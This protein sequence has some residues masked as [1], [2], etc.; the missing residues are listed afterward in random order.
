MAARSGSLR[1]YILT[2]LLLVI[3]NILV[4]LTM[5][6]LLMRVAPGD[7]VSAAL[8]G[9]LPPD[10]IA[11]RREAAGFDRPL[12]V[13]YW[14]YVSGV[15]RLDFG[16]TLTDNR[17][18]T[19]IFIVNGGATLTLTVAA[20]LVALVVGIPLGLYAGRRRDT[21][22]DVG[23][24]LFGILT[25]AAPV[26]FVGVLAQMLFT[27]KLGWLPSGKQAGAITQATTEEV[28]H[29][30]LLD[31]VLAGSSD[32]FIDGLKHLVMPAVVLGLLVTGVFIRLIRV[33]VAQ[34][35]RDDYV[36]AAQA[37]GVP[38]KKVVRHHAFR[39]ALVPFITVLGLQVALLF[40][41]AILTEQTFSWPGVGS[42]LIRYLTNRDYAAVQGIITVFALIVVLISL[43]I[44][45]VNALI[46]PRVR[47]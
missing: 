5:V 41:G 1:R 40:G 7:P 44:D 2:R 45:I 16:T 9:R 28:T 33:N 36:E 20:M 8:G 43:L 30:F 12:I 29:I 35:M 42:Q 18:V 3:P 10:E 46:D 34:T 4:L 32:A 13:Q 14:E 39:N 24:R 25:Y 15:L 19:E 23:I 38:E 47:Y 31:A 22:S 6:F 27:T 37:R 21:A 26:F 17:D 11:R